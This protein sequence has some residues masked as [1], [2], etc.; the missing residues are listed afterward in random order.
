MTKHE[1]YPASETADRFDRL[2]RAAIKTPPSH[3]V[4]KKKKPKAAKRRRFRKE[5]SE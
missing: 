2:L 5:T 1:E 3:H 4:A